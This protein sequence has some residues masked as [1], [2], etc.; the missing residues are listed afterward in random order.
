LEGDTLVIKRIT[1]RYELRVA[2]DVDRAVIQRV[3]E[4]HAGHCPVARSIGGCIAIT[5][6]V[7]LIAD[8]PGTG[9]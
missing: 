3:L 8:D 2:P 6:D 5:T 1:V 7:D 9:E 4:F